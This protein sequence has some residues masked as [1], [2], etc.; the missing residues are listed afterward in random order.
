MFTYIAIEEVN[1]CACQATQDICIHNKLYKSEF[2]SAVVNPGSTLYVIN[3]II[4]V[5]YF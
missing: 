1:Y 2:Y 5:P 3:N 4:Y